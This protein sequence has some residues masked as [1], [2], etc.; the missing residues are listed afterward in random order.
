[1]S[2]ENPL[3]P[4]PS[5]RAGVPE[6]Q[7]SSGELEA[8]IRR[9]VELQA[10]EA[11]GGPGEGLTESELIR[12]GRELGLSPAHV[13][14]ALAEVRS[15][16]SPER[17]GWFGRGFGDAAVLSSRHVSRSAESVRRELEVYM[18]D[19]ECMVVQRRLP[20]RTVY[21]QASGVVAAV[22]RAA[23]RVGSRYP[24]LGARQIEV[25]VQPVDENSCF[26]S[27][28][29]DL[30]GQRTGLAAGG[31]LGGGGAGGITAAM[32]AIAIAPPAALV[33]V[34][35]LIG[36]VL[37]ARAIYS[38]LTERMRVQIESLL[39]RLEHRELL[40]PGGTWPRLPGR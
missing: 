7:L 36:A 1:M 26:V 34:P 31:L 2:A 12:I 39:D 17:E 24:P 10:R 27:L 4:A 9:A 3:V 35:L 18:R 30:S 29:V 20:D 25:A 21:V 11:E 37:S 40:P 15:R 16:P 33:G 38:Q 32:A 28:A 13:Q 19:R 5:E 14:Q 22:S 23:Q 8:V 6:R